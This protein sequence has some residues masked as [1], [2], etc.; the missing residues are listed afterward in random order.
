M[1]AS[2]EQHG[3]FEEIDV[4]NDPIDHTERKGLR[5]IKG[6]GRV[7]KLTRFAR[8]DQ[9]GQKIAA[10]KSPENPILAK[11]VTRR[12]DCAAMCRSQASASDRPA[13]AAGPFTMAIVGLGISCNSRDTSILP[14]KWVTASSTLRSLEPSA[15]LLSPL[16]R[17]HDRRR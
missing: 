9:L 1:P 11:A 5:G 2:G 8:A 10:A 16:H 3:G 14:R 15:M 12:A 17:T 7:V 13:P 4:R 6:L